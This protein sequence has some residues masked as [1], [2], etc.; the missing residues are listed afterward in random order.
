MDWVRGEQE[1][2]TGVAPCGAPGQGVSALN[3]L[4]YLLAIQSSVKV[5][6]AIGE[7]TLATYWQKKA[8]RLGQTLLARF[9]DEEHG[10]FSDTMGKD[11]FS[12]HAQAMGI[13][14]GLLTGARRESAL[15]ALI[16]G[17]CPAKVSSYFAYYFFEALA[18]CGRAD[19]ILDR[20]HCWKDLVSWGA[21]TAFETQ[22][23]DSR[24]DCHAWS[25]CPLY[26]LQSAVAGIR[27]ASPCYGR[28]RVEPQPGKLKWIRAVA[29]T[30]KGKVA[31]DLKFKDGGAYGSI[32]LPPGLEGDFVWKGVARPLKAGMN[33]FP[34]SAIADVPQ[35]EDLIRGPE[36]WLN[37]YG[38]NVRKDGLR[39]DLESIKSAGL[40][41]VHLFH[42][43]NRSED[44][45]P[46]PDCPEQVPV[47]SEKWNDLISFIGTECER[48][49][50][51]LTLQNCPGW[52]QSGGPW[53]AITNAMRELRYSRQDWT[54]E[55]EVRLPEV[56][57]IYRD[58]DSDWR[59]VAVLAFPTPKDD[60]G[61]V[62]E[63]V[64]KEGAGD[65]VT[66]A[67][68]EPITVRTLVLP[69][70]G[71]YNGNLAYHAPWLR[72]KLTAIDGE[73]GE[74]TV[75]DSMLPVS[76]WRDSDGGW[77]VSLACDECKARRWRLEYVHSLPIIRYDE[78]QFLAAARQ[79]DWEGKS[80]LTLRSL[81]RE[82]TPCQDPS[83]WVRKRSIVDL[84]DR[85][86][87]DGRLMWKPP[88][89]KWTVLRFGHVNTKRVNAPAP[90]V[91]T[92]WECDKL[93]AEG[94]EANFR[95]YVGRL[96]EGVL[97]GKV[98]GMLVD[99]WECFGQTW[100]PQMERYFREANGYEVRQKLPAL[101][102]WVLDDP[103]KT[104]DFLTDWRRTIGNLIT[105]N[106]Y[107]RMAKLAHDVGIEV[108]Y[109]TAIGDVV[110][111][112][113]LE[114]WKY[115]DAPMCE[116]WRPRVSEDEG[117]CGTYSYK[118][119][120]PCTSA[121]H[122]YG[123][124]RVVAEAFTGEGITWS[125]DFRELREI[126]NQHFARGVTHLAFQSYTH[127]PSP[128][129]LPPGGCMG[130]FNGTPF[131][132]LQTWWKYMPE[133]T[134]WVARCEEFLEAGVPAQDILWYLGDAVDYKPDENF[135]L[136]EGYRADYLNH[137][138]LTNRL[139]VKDGVFR[140]PEGATWRVL[141]IPDDYRMLPATK[142]RLSELAA[143]GGKVVI[144]D[145]EALVT[146]LSELGLGKDVETEKSL[147]DGL[148]DDFGWIHRKVGDS[149]RY[150][151]TAGTN[152][153]RGKVTFRAKGLARIVDPVSQEVFA[154]R[155]G[156][157]FPLQASQSVFVV[158][159]AEGTSKNARAF[160]T[161]YASDNRRVRK[162]GPW[163]LAFP[164]GRT[165]ALETPESWSALAGLSR[166]ERAF[167]G[168]AA[169]MSEFDCEQDGERV[170]LDLGAVETIAD[171]FVNGHRVRTLWCE[172]YACDITDF[173]RTGRNDLR[174][175]VV[176][177]WRNRVIFDLGQPVEKRQTWILYRNEYNPSAKDPFVPAGLLGPVSLQVCK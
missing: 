121:A 151:V 123:K 172:P 69:P 17:T 126:A 141:W 67:F 99:S 96:T 171:V 53:I 49:G 27:P 166:E 107:G 29:P 152:G 40:S 176:N 89:G 131:T 91:A 77:T 2:D 142:R 108:F 120:R 157:E 24:S 26:F 7:T 177:T 41:G 161:R 119:I 51:G 18:Q 73:S 136:P 58:A 33:E 66:Y 23:N 118:P 155:N 70:L 116:F 65:S 153:Y 25:A 138:V 143:A 81:M 13:L 10:L 4:Q 150:F 19:V 32:A 20:L 72:A 38:G 52:S 39:C 30:P 14:T 169:Y 104:E 101:F 154:W 158:F 117:G 60:S 127:A 173:V 71:R 102:G 175:E 163:K 82:A 156:E 130:G 35:S 85:V 79:T 56:P 129:A 110:P 9:W 134:G 83:A 5:D 87:S 16:D 145:K 132:R 6:A 57:A 109:E 74:K 55:G 125:E 165:V 1:F 100:T 47:L 3:N 137:D 174:I 86:S 170:V 93:S 34:D 43:G 61:T 97:K 84:T 146:A 114:Y 68:A 36:V 112:D 168:T 92:G 167:S 140:I 139:E 135:P 8:D 48:L 64:R 115:A 111:G 148:R 94:I 113:I 63:P 147:G 75:F 122:I 124:R 159:D 46:W 11:R 160:A 95:G 59:D 128:N 98:R 90:V 21:R 88:R 45:C 144:G 15:K 42:I 37:L 162:V 103:T 133:F 50:L 105:R 31:V 12:E 44:D 80:G 62:L 54:G 149:D 28:V 106:Y 76:N 164:N 78:P 22:Y